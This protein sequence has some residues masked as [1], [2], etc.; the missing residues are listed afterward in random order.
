M[1]CGQLRLKKQEPYTPPLETSAISA[2]ATRLALI[3]RAP[4]KRPVKA[5]GYAGR[6]GVSKKQSSGALPPPLDPPVR[7]WLA[8]HGLAV[9]TEDFARH[10]ITR[11]RLPHLTR[12][13][14]AFMGLPRSVQNMMLT[15]LPPVVAMSV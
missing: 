14:L 11:N 6:Y 15:L 3:R 9:Y 2:A 12:E 13:E 5:S 4:V 7:D 8:Q 1:R 10:K